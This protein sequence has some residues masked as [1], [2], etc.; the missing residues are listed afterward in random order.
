MGLVDKRVSI[1]VL[2]ENR[3]WR[4]HGV[5][6]AGDLVVEVEQSDKLLA[7]GPAVG[8]G[9]L[10]PRAGKRR[11]SSCFTCRPGREKDDKVRRIPRI[12]HSHARTS[13]APSDTPLH[14]STML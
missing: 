12:E 3:V 14:D 10:P 7:R 1:G 5:F 6:A 4:N 13:Q 2:Y 8:K 11:L 9:R